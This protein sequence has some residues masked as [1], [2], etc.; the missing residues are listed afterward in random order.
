[1]TTIRKAILGSVVAVAT[2]GGMVLPAAARTSVD[3]YVNYGAPPPAYYEVTPAPRVGYTWVPGYWDWRGHRHH[4]VAGHWIRARP[5]YVYHAPRWYERDGRWH[6]AQ[7]G[8]RYGDADRDGV[9]NR[10][11]NAPHNPYRN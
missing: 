5:G 11:D 7:G 2:M 8:W 4:W 9:P 10:Y 3:L 1:M 6:I